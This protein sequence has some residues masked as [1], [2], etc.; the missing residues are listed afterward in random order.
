MSAA[1]A[2]RERI[3]RLIEPLRAHPE[4]AAVLCDV[5]GTLAPITARPDQTLVPAPVRQA[6]A[7]IADRYRLVACVSGRPAA[8]ARALV[9]LD[10]IVYLGNHGLETLGAG[11]GEP[12]L[13]PAATAAA[14]RARELVESLDAARLATVGLRLEDKGP[15]QALHWR[16]AESLAAAELEAREVAALAQA[17]GLEPH[18]GRRVLELRPPTG[19]DKGTS[20]ERLVAGAG[21]DSALYGGDDLTDL[22]AFTGLD[23][24]LAAGR[25]L[26]AVRV[27]VGSPEGPA[28]LVERCDL[29]VD[30]TEGFRAVLEALT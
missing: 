8:T 26:H 28:A 7:R 1:P 30:G 16:G 5:D 21:V 4:R 29:L 25:L 17:S 10:G 20:V 9:G 14:G 19:I 6:L 3:A 22:D 15:I 18:W 23:R 11:A 27:G 2:S 24:L 12:E 13:A